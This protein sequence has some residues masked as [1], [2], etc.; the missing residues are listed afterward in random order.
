MPIF[1]GRSKFSKKSSLLSEDKKK[2]SKDKSSNNSKASSKSPPPISAP[3]NVFKSTSKYSNTTTTTTPI[4]SSIPIKSRIP[5]PGTST[6]FFNT[7]QG[8]ESLSPSITESSQITDSETS[9]PP[10]QTIPAPSNINIPPIKK[11]NSLPSPELSSQNTAPTRIPQISSPS[12]PDLKQQPPYTSPPS[13]PKFSTFSNQNSTQ[14]YSSGSGI[15]QEVSITGYEVLPRRGL[16]VTVHSDDIY[17][18]GGRANKRL[19]NDLVK[20]D[21]E[22]F[23]AT[24]INANGYIPDPREGHASAFIG[25]TMFVFGGELDNGNCDDNL[26]AFNIGNEMWYKVPISG[27]QLSGRKGHTA[28]SVGSSFF[29][30]GGTVDGYYLHDLAYF[31]VRLAATEGP[32]WNFV[33]S[34]GK[35]PMGRAGHT[36]NFYNDKLYIYGGMCGNLCFNDLWSFSISEKK[37]EQILLRGATPPARYGH[38]STLVDDCIFIMGGRTI[39]GTAITDFFA[40]KISSQRWYTFPVQS[41]KWPHRVDPILSLLKNRLILFSGN[42][43]LALDSNVVNILDTNKIKIM[44]DTKTASSQK[45][46]SPTDPKVQKRNT[47]HSPQSQSNSQNSKGTEDASENGANKS[48]T[49]ESSK[50]PN[51]FQHRKF[52]FDPQPTHT[53]SPSL[54][55]PR[56]QEKSFSNEPSLPSSSPS[57]QHSMRRHNPSEYVGSSSP[58]TEYPKAQPQPSNNSPQFISN[59]APSKPT[60]QNHTTESQLSSRNKISSPNLQ[61]NNYQPS[62]ENRSRLRAFSSPKTAPLKSPHSIEK[63][64]SLGARSQSLSKELTTNNSRSLNTHPSNPSLNYSTISQVSTNESSVSETQPNTSVPKFMLRHP[65]ASPSFPKKSLSKSLSKESSASSAERKISEPTSLQTSVV[66]PSFSPQQPPQT[67][68]APISSQRSASVKEVTSPSI[69]ESTKELPPRNPLL[70]KHHPSNTYASIEKDS[71]SSNKSLTIQLRNRLSF[72]ENDSASPPSKE[73]SDN[74]LI[75]AT[76]DSIS[77]SAATRTNKA[78]LN[79]HNDTFDPTQASKD[80]NL[81]NNKEYDQQFDEDDF[82]NQEQDTKESIDSTAIDV[83]KISFDDLGP[84]SKKKSIS[85][86]HSNNSTVEDI[87]SPE[88]ASNVKEILARLEDKYG[89]TDEQTSLSLEKA[90]NS[91]DS[92]PL[93]SVNSLNPSKLAMLVVALN[94]ELE[95]TKKLL[96]DSMKSSIER[97]YE[98]ERG[99]RAALQ[100]AIYL[101]TKVFALA[102]GNFDMLSKVNA[103]RTLDLEKQ[104]ANIINENVSLRNHVADSSYS[105]KISQERLAEYQHEVESTR[106]QLLRMDQ[107]YRFSNASIAH[108]ENIDSSRDPNSLNSENSDLKSDNTNGVNRSI[109]L[110]MDG[111]S[112]NAAYSD[113]IANLRKEITDLLSRQEELLGDVENA[114]LASNAA[115]ERSDKLQKMLTV[116][117][118]ENTFIREEMTRLSTSFEL[119]KAKSAKLNSKLENAESLLEDF[120]SQVSALSEITSNSRNFEMSKSRDLMNNSSSILNTSQNELTNSP[121]ALRSRNMSNNTDIGSL[122]HQ[123]YDRASRSKSESNVPL[124][125]IPLEGKSAPDIQTAFLST[126]KQWLQSRTEVMNLRQSLREIE[127]R[128][129]LSESQ[130]AQKDRELTNALARIDA[131]TKLV[132]DLENKRKSRET[133]NR[134]KSVPSLYNGKPS[135][136]EY[137]TSIENSTSKSYSAADLNPPKIGPGFPIKNTSSSGGPSEKTLDGSNDQLMNTSPEKVLMSKRIDNRTFSEANDNDQLFDENQTGVVGAHAARKSTN[138]NFSDERLDFS[139]SDSPQGYKNPSSR[140]VDNNTAFANSHKSSTANTATDSSFYGNPDHDLDTSPTNSDNKPF[141]HSGFEKENAN[142]SVGDGFDFNDDTIDDQNSLSLML[143][144][145]HQLQQPYSEST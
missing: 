37:W 96:N 42:A 79:I 123:G 69:D 35:Y 127:E 145:L 124:A 46:T 130:L 39:D 131:F 139:Y 67:T 128:K 134:A 101:K 32:T 60:E 63:S 5:A 45:P 62:L 23:E 11:T 19:K 143:S 115:N 80:R 53:S 126:Q 72:I 132:I 137:Q 43:T 29:V 142:T 6:N 54:H 57:L 119:E 112:A 21:S 12:A 116:A 52:S 122:S 114:L 3:N 89:I 10:H 138:E 18:F 41:S 44:P 99:K 76:K 30:F 94:K 66:K 48:P 81:D 34:E 84:S 56:F 95:S 77:S 102:S 9:P 58:I 140:A 59:I 61:E 74:S 91:K 1:F 121:P 50:L 65:S 16:S 92:L 68:F 7:T 141:I 98:A 51:S 111:G 93:D 73:D 15:W 87:T 85:P 117:E 106:Q 8:K 36:C 33:H 24:L 49:P 100:E 26:Y 108:S 86:N 120:R 70:F 110:N 13:Q 14:P 125:S 31:N 135:F 104:L 71:S 27:P 75:S 107:M 118:Q 25:R 55:H 22:T 2:N 82:R 78:D 97:V 90:G 144:A 105:L 64:P 17:L 83:S 28:I 40:Y 109:F 113:E 129:I 136:A 47:I 38:A 133:R 103:Q 88:P 4:P 20:L